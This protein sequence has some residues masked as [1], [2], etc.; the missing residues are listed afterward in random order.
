MRGELVD[1]FVDVVDGEVEDGVGRRR[2]VRHLVDQR[3]PV[4]GEVQPHQAVF[5]GCL[6]PKRLAVELPGLLQVVH[7]NAAVCLGVR[8]HDWLIL[9]E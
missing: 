2:K 8:E 7:S 3:V 9:G 6:E 5:L 4:A 1:G